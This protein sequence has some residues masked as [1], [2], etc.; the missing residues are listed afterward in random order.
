MFSSYCQSYNDVA[1]DTRG[2]EDT[3]AELHQQVD[4]STGLLVLKHVGGF[5][6]LEFLRCAGC[7]TKHMQLNSLKH[8]SLLPD[9]VIDQVVHFT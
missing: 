8:F 3:K 6:Q 4:V 1:E 5:P 9:S 7:S 2:D